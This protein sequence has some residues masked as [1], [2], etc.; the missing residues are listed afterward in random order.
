MASRINRGRAQPAGIRNY[1][2]EVRGGSRGRDP[3]GLD[4]EIPVTYLIGGATFTGDL[5]G[6]QPGL[7]EGK[8]PARRSR[9]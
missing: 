3:P 6:D 9:G 1:E 4:I 8:R 5:P 7:T 2:A